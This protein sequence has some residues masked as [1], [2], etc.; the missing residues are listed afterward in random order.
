M[1][2]TLRSCARCS[3]R[4]RPASWPCSQCSSRRAA[5][6]LIGPSVLHLVGSDEVLRVLGELGVILLLLEVGLQMDLTELGSVGRSSLL[7]ATAGVAAPFALGYGVMSAFGESGNT[8]L[9]V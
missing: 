8:A 5:G 7:V 6:I 9:F 3:R 1:F 4:S 2:R